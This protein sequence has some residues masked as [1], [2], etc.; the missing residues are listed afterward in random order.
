[1]KTYTFDAATSANLLDLMGHPGRLTV[2]KLITEKEWDVGSLAQQVGLSQSALSQHLAKLR[3][4]KL[5][6]TRRDRQT[7]YYSSNSNAVRKVLAT[8]EKLALEP[9]RNTRSKVTEAA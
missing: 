6:E 8:L 2:L 4:G 5:V 9:V 3:A 7:V 1:M